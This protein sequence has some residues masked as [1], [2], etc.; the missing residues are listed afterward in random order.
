MTESSIPHEF[1]SPNPCP[2]CTFKYSA[3][4]FLYKVPDDYLSSQVNQIIE[5]N[6]SGPHFQQKL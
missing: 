4:L 6:V 1:Y 2:Q 5:Q 3:E